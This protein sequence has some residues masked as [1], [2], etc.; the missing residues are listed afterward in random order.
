MHPKRS[1]VHSYKAVMENREF[2]PNA[3]GRPPVS[4]DIY[5]PQTHQRRCR[6]RDQCKC[7]FLGDFGVALTKVQLVEG[8]SPLDGVAPQDVPV[9]LVPWLRT[10]EHFVMPRALQVAFDAFESR[11][12]EREKQL[13]E[14]A[15]QRAEEAAA[16]QRKEVAK[17]KR[18][19]KRQA[20]QRAQDQE[21]EQQRAEAARVAL[22]ARSRTVP[23]AQ[24]G[25]RCSWRAERG[26]RFDVCRRDERRTRPLL[27]SAARRRRAMKTRHRATKTTHRAMKATHRAMKTGHRATT[28]STARA[29]MTEIL[30]LL[31][32]MSRSSTWRA[33]SCGVFGVQLNS[34]T[35]RYGMAWTL[36]R[37]REGKGGL[38]TP[39]EKPPAYGL[40][41]VQVQKTQVRAS[42][43]QGDSHRKL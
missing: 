41:S 39:L 2:S 5:Q 9:K 26:S 28:T 33:V 21:A 19:A 25:V 17:K 18:E 8:R 22:E 23:P 34:P 30:S 15:K 31:R 36:P 14:A 40:R 38:R 13:E 4:A 43:E 27:L 16:N 1:A 32:R 20:E 3:H 37:M 10:Q 24:R 6:R 35:P 12:V 7:E 29:A 42:D 11:R